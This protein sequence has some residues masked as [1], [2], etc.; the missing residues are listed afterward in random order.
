MLEP[1]HIMFTFA[2]L[3]CMPA[4]SFLNNFYSSIYRAILRCTIWSV[5]LI[6]IS[7]ATNGI[8]WT[9]TLATWLNITRSW[10]RERN[11]SVPFPNIS[12]LS[13]IF[14]VHSSV[15]IFLPMTC[16]RMQQHTVPPDQTVLW[17]PSSTTFCYFSVFIYGCFA[18]PLYYQWWYHWL[19]LRNES[20]VIQH[21]ARIWWDE[22]SHILLGCIN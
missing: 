2:G 4:C 12:K 17:L 18:H 22:Y 8:M 14:K 11:W 6:Q 3:T 5:Y 21:L 16:Q 9:F 20:K 19:Q 1:Q 10:Y 13:K 15:R 7:F